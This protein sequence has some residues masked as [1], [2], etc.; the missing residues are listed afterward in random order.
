MPVLGTPNAY[1]RSI[2]AYRRLILARDDL[3]ENALYSLLFPEECV[4]LPPTAQDQ[5]A[6]VPLVR[7][8]LQFQ[9]AVSIFGI[10]DAV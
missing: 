9:E 1:A 10:T 7:I 8:I 3:L 6:C 5:V 4:S 2:T